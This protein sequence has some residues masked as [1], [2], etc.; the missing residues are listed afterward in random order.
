M[1]NTKY[2][3]SDYHINLFEN[4][5]AFFKIKLFFYRV[6]QAI[7]QKCISVSFLVL[8][9]VEECRK[10]A[11]YAEF[12]HCKV[13]KFRNP[14]H[15]TTIVVLMLQLV[16]LAHVDG[17]RHAPR[18]YVWSVWSIEVLKSPSSVLGHRCFDRHSSRLPSVFRPI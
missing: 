15:M 14:F 8:C 2:Q 9:K 6:K 3:F 13:I 18:S 16:F 17:I 1:K 12:T 7:L 10:S 11:L 5:K 4:L